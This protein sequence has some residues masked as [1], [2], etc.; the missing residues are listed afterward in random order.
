MKYFKL[1]TCKGHDNDEHGNDD[2]KVR[3]FYNVYSKM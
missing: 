1:V 3:V 2:F